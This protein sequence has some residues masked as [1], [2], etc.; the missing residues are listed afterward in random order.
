MSRNTR[1]GLRPF[2]RN[3]SYFGVDVDQLLSDRDRASEIFER[4]SICS[5]PGAFRPLPYRV[6]S[7]DETVDAFRL[8]QQSGHIGKIVL[9]PPRAPMQPDRMPNSGSILRAPIFSPVGSA[10]F[11]LRDGRW[12]GR[13]GVAI[14]F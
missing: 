7:A 3:L 13:R 6:Y 2:R 12:L 11:G 4:S 8:M 5:K 9:R 1:I 14:S 10:A